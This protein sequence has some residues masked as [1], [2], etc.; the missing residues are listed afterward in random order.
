MQ[1]FLANDGLPHEAVKIG[2][3]FHAF[4]NFTKQTF[5]ASCVEVLKPESL[6]LQSGITASYKQVWSSKYMTLPFLMFYR[7]PLL[8]REVIAVCNSV[9]S[10][11]T[12]EE[13]MH[14]INV[15]DCTKALIHCAS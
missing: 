15:L 6:L 7:C 9:Y 10:D 12:V 3:N 1:H 8:G 4:V 11:N 5:S 14:G 2:Q 13:E